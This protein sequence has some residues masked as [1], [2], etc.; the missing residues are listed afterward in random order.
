VDA[1]VE[2]LLD[3]PAIPALAAD[4]PRQGTEPR[5]RST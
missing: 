2:A 5:S 4:H 3:H 1:V